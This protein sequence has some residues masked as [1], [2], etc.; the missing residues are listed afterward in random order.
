M[1]TPFVL[2]DKE[3]Q[4]CNDDQKPNA[5][6]EMIYRLTRIILIFFG[7]YLLLNQAMEHVHRLKANPCCQAPSRA[8]DPQVMY[9]ES[10]TLRISQVPDDHRSSM[11]HTY[12]LE[13]VQTG[14]VH[15]AVVS[16]YR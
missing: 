7:L 10:A 2:S 13:D 11:S 4:M 5:C 14:K 15:F 6:A 1:I 8:A 16:T 12:R 3:C 9:F